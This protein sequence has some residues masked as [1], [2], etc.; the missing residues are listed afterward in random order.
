MYEHVLYSVLA[1]YYDVIYQGYLTSVVPRLVDF[2]EEVFKRDAGRPVK[3]VLDLACGT[4]GPTLELAK[5]GYSVMGVDLHSEMLKIAEEKAS[6]LGVNVKFIQG[7][8]RNIDFNEEFDAVTMF[9]TSISYMTSSEDLEKLLRNVYKALKPGGVFIAD[10][11]N[12][13][14]FA[15]TL[16]KKE[17]PS[18][19]DVPHDDERI[20]IIDYREVENVTAVVY[21]KRIITIVKPDGSSKTYF[22]ND[23]IRLYT[24]YELK[25]S[26]KDVGF[27][28]VKIY[29]D[30]NWAEEELKNANRLF[31]VARK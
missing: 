6:K 29:G 20:I 15:F 24:A 11:P 19:W 27:N 16:G 14:A 10:A 30:L 26:A 22:M 17:G 9:F 21:F 28:Y 3:E 18:I 12:P 7:D 2:V 13:I 5:R 23:K 25:T 31:L 8:V 4:G 1:R